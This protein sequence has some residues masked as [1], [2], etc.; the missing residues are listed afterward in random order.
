M[1]VTAFVSGEACPFVSDRPLMWDFRNVWTPA[2]V[3]AI[4][5]LKHWIE[6]KMLGALRTSVY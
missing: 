1:I 4:L 5:A 3:K 2:S 6:E